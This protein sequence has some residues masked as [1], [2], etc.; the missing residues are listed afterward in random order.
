[1]GSK[2]LLLATGFMMVLGVAISDTEQDKTECA[3]QLVG[4]ATCLPYVGGTAKT[5]ALDCC[6][7]LKQVL[8]KS[9]KCL[10][11]L[12]KD[13]D[14]PSLGIKI[15]ATLAAT[16]PSACKAPANVTQCIDILHLAPNSTDAKV[17]AGFA[18]IAKGSNSSSTGASE[19]KSDGGMGK[20][21]KWVG[22]EM[23]ICG[24]LLWALTAFGI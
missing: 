3:N 20:R 13:R 15:N 1:M 21:S 12:I 7:G 14:D 6:T 18:N 17:F 9:T 11:L 22:V 5:P 19:E 24:Y 2:A 23:M 10:C 8:E 4:L 16:L